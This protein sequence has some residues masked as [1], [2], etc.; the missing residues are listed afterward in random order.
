MHHFR[1]SKQNDKSDKWAEVPESWFFCGMT[2][3]FHNWWIK[4]KKYN[5]WSFSHLKHVCLVLNLGQPV[6]HRFSSTHVLVFVQSDGSFRKSFQINVNSFILRE[7]SNLDNYRQ[8][9]STRDINI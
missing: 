5:A 1:K 7:I 4:F 3:F 2:S 9:L 6:K 8:Q